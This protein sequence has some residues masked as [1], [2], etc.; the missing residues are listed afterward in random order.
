M[1]IDKAQCL[2]VNLWIPPNILGIMFCYL[3]HIQLFKS[4]VNFPSSFWFYLYLLISDGKCWNKIL[5]S[6]N[7][8][9]PQEVLM[10]GFNKR[11]KVEKGFFPLLSVHGKCLIAFFISFLAPISISFIMLGVYQG[12]HMKSRYTLYYHCI[13]QTLS[14][15]FHCN[16]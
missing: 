10:Y 12:V 16:N 2:K 14:N 13:S 9:Y 5:A 11:K 1:S 15:T 4:P 3:E 8:K 6:K 7:I